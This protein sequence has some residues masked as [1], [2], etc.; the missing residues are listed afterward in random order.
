ME[1]LASVINARIY[2]VALGEFAGRLKI[3]TR[4]SIV[5]ASLLEDLTNPDLVS[6]YEV[7]MKRFDDLFL[8]IPRPSFC[9]IDVEGSELQVLQG[10]TSSF[11]CIDYFFI[12]TSINSLYKDGPELQDVCDILNNNGFCFFDIGGVCR[13]PYDNALHQIDAIF[14]RKDSKLRRVKRWN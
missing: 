14:V 5:H 11:E 7:E 6:E 1:R 9:K 2:N 12:E 4:R 13:R 8:T 3:K 10:M